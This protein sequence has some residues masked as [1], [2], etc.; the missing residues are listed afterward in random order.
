MVNY[1]YI[2][3]WTRTVAGCGSCGTAR[4]VE[5]LDVNSPAQIIFSNRNFIA[6]PGTTYQFTTD[7]AAQIE[8]WINEKTYSWQLI[9]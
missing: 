5:N 8:Q 3:I 6:R 9:P 4:K 7:E 2:G 1:K